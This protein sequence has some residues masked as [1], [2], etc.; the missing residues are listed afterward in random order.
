MKRKLNR[1]GKLTLFLLSLGLLLGISTTLKKTIMMEK[2]PEINVENEYYKI[3]I[4]KPQITSASVQKEIDAWIDHSVKQLK[5]EAMESKQ[6]IEENNVQYE[7][8]LNPEIHQYG[9]LE[10]IHLTEYVFTGGN[11]YMRQD[12]TYH[13]D[14]T[15]KE[16]KNITDFLKNKETDFTRLAYLSKMKLMEYSK[17]EQL[18]LDSEWIAEGT[19]PTTEHYEY[20]YFTKDG[21]TIV[22]PPYQV[23]PWSAGEIKI[24]LENKEIETIMNLPIPNEPS[25]IVPFKRDVNDLVGKKLLAFTFDDGPAYQTT[26]YLLKE[27]KKRNILVTFF[28]LG[29]RI[30]NYP[31]IVKQAYLD[32][33]NIASHTY[34]HTDLLK[35]NEYQ[36]YQEIQKTNQAIYQITETWPKYLRPPYGNTN[37]QIKKNSGLNTI[38]WSIDTEDWK[39][40]DRSKVAQAILKNAEDG[41]I[42][43]LHDLYQS[44]VEG[45][46]LAM[47]EL[48]KQNYE[49]VTIEEMIQLRGINLDSTKSY[50]SF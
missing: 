5:N 15:S 22:F 34:Q 36:V 10:T 24:T 47:D 1:K 27:L 50:Y 23:G 33:H 13:I 19:S 32:G 21:L 9:N 25:S 37:D 18:L 20:F 6:Y 14:T 49:F 26:D 3:N 45:A 12:K 29:S 35:L 16:Q 40:R 7:L 39:Y 43:L 31:E 44:S 41:D 38:L 2:K 42:I 4:K 11:H 8:S 46:L 28:M 48:K 17:Q 30:E